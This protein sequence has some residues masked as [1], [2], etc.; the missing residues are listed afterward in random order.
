MPG[1]GA[2]AG[3]PREDAG[4]LRLFRFR[5]VQPAFDRTLR[6]IMLP[7]LVALPGVRAIHLGRQ[8]PDETG[9]RVVAS[10]WDSPAAMIAAVGESFDAPT[11][12]P[13][14]IDDT[15]DKRL[16]VVPLRLAFEPRQPIE[17]RVVRVVFGRTKPGARDD[18]IGL[19]E[20]G[21]RSDL[22][23][24]SGPRALYLGVRDADRFVT[25]SVWGHWS[26]IARATGGS[27]LAPGATRHDE[28]LL[29]WTVVHYEAVPS[30]DGTILPLVR[31]APKR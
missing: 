11:F 15:T 1:R 2:G 29:E 28:L 24:G 5:P 8:G 23:A 22:A 21:T 25:V 14:F 13:E 17:E 20:R 26:A 16:D 30:G 19:V 10:V 18:Y 12:H 31:A 4:V 27:V 3:S 9:E 6:D 7:D